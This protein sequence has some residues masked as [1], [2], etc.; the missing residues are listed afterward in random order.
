MAEAPDKTLDVGDIKDRLFWHRR[1]HPEPNTECVVE[2]GY[3]AA[4]SDELSLMK[5]EEVVILTPKGDK[6]GYWWEAQKPD[7]TR[8][9]VPINFLRYKLDDTLFPDY[10][11]MMSKVYG[12]GTEVVARA[13]C[14]TGRPIDGLE[15][16]K[17]EKGDR[18]IIINP[19]ESNPGWYRARLMSSSGKPCKLQEGVV[20]GNILEATYEAYQKVFSSTKKP[21]A[22]DNE[23]QPLYDSFEEFQQYSMW[24]TFRGCEN[25]S[26]D[27]LYHRLAS[28]ARMEYDEFMQTK[29]AIYIMR[30][31]VSDECYV[32]GARIL[33]KELGG[34]FLTWDKTHKSRFDEECYEVPG[35]VDWQLEVTPLSPTQNLNV[36]RAKKILSN[37]ALKPDGLNEEMVFDN[38][39]EWTEFITWLLPK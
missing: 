26:L 29:Q 20:H 14:D 30:Q 17:F 31:K 21:K 38:N 3:S 18:M 15:T 37:N 4:E 28:M 11:I 13:N 16:L 2:F 33:H 12:S 35:F 8:G 9:V 6:R 1:G 23:P 39:E 7:G 24:F 27:A 19:I 10:E 32:G 25:G 34:H 5:G 22:E 36:E